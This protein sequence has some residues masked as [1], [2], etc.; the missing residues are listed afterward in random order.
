[1]FRTNRLLA[2]CLLPLIVG[3]EAPPR[4]SA[5]EVPTNTYFGV[6]VEEP[7]Q[8]LDDWTNT[9]VQAWSDSQTEKARACLDALPLRAE[10]HEDFASLL[11]GS[12]EDEYF[13]PTYRAGHLTVWRYRSDAQQP[14]LL[15]FEYPGTPDDAVTLFD[16][17]VED[18]SGQ[19]S[20]S[21]YKP[22]PSGRYVA[23]ALSSGG[24]E[25]AKLRVIDTNDGTQIGQDIPNVHN[26][27]AGGDFVWLNDESGF[28]YTR[29]PL[30]GEA[31]ESRPNM[32]LKAYQHDLMHDDWHADS[33]VLGSNFDMTTQVRFVPGGQGTS[34]WVQDGDS[35]RFAYFR[36]NSDVAHDSFAQHSR[37]DDKHF[38]FIEGD[39]GDLFALSTS[40]AARGRILRIDT[41]TNDDP[42]EI[43]AE[44]ATGTLNH[45]YYSHSSP[46]AIWHEQRLIVAYNV[47]GPDEIRVFDRD[48]NLQ[49]IE[50]IAGAV[51]ITQLTAVPGGVLFSAES[52]TRPAR[53]MRLD[54]DSG[55]V[56]DS[57]ALPG[58]GGKGW[59]DVRVERL[60]ATSK[61]GTQVPVTVLLP[62]GFDA[63]D[64]PVRAFFTGYG[65]FR[66]SLRPRFHAE[67]RALLDRNVI[68]AE[69]ILRGGGEFG[70]DWHREGALTQK[71]NV[72][73]DF[74]AAIRHVQ[75]L[76][77]TTPALSS[78]LGE[79]NGGLLIGA[80]IVQHPEILAAAVA[81]VG[82][83][84]ML[85]AELD[86][87]G[88]YNIPEYG[89]VKDEAQFRALYAYSPYHNV[90]DE[91]RYP[92][93]LLTTGANDQ[94][95]NPKH[96]RKM[97]ARLLEAN[98]AD[99]PILL[100]AERTGGH[101]V[102]ASLEQQISELSDEYAFLLHYSAGESK[103]VECAD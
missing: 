46:T 85:S 98:K 49:D 8:W 60:H 59:D 84:D 30:P 29:Y 15:R 23:I 16:L 21:W 43:V 78:A 68:V 91:T 103:P 73:D 79:S 38:Q 33:M 44:A 74:A 14:E 87:N 2:V 55:A 22:S 6:T 17:N 70:A 71:Q 40:G 56:S 88:I 51:S 27:T 47:G 19:T 80:T 37:Y 12:G 58:S 101:G 31:N 9:D 67:Y 26:P 32:F 57:S 75:S 11:S 83:F 72:F 77:W 28:V 42:V 99:T 63:D 97:A 4:S 13:S 10:L 48:G 52:Y 41:N 96:S 20:F 86:P 102:G 5:P 53:W 76:G 25:R 50:A 69:V 35:G 54:L 92:A 3:C 93:T 94:R 18:P 62:P 39:N 82:L 89:T 66:Y 64:G 65:G 24:S 1:M 34:A 36:R 45:S 81:K 61:D 95:V 7:H 100:R 90:G